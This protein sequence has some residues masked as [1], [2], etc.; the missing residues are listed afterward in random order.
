M[1]AFEAFYKSL[2]FND[3]TEQK[4]EDTLI[5]IADF[6]TKVSRSPCA[7]DTEHY[8]YSK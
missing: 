7:A 3:S 1:K 4:T 5:T 8:A 6:F 2:Q